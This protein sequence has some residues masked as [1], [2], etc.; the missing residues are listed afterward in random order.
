MSGGRT[1]QLESSTST[2]YLQDLWVAN[3]TDL[4]SWARVGPAQNSWPGRAGHVFALQPPLSQ[5]DFI[6]S[7]VVAGG[8]GPAGPLPDVWVMH[9]YDGP[10]GYQWAEDYSPEQWF[11]QVRQAAGRRRPRPCRWSSHHSSRSMHGSRLAGCRRAG[12]AC[13]QGSGSMFEYRPGSPQQYYVDVHTPVERVVRH[14]LPKARSDPREGTVKPYLTDEQVG[15]RLLSLLHMSWAR[16]SR[17]LHG[18]DCLSRV[19]WAAC[20][21]GWLSPPFPPA[22]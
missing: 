11:R 16:V 2:R 7:L 19:G 21:P 4:T 6:P 10:F 13:M 1:G 17:G 3:L 18:L 9:L 8:E 20:L 12:A 14:Y 5:N 22:P 15:C